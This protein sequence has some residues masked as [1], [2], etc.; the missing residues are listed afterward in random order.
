M[1]IRVSPH[2]VDPLYRLRVEFV[3]QHGRHGMPRGEQVLTGIADGTLSG[4]LLDDQQ[5]Y[6]LFHLADYNGARVVWLDELYLSPAARK[7]G[8]LQEFADWL[9][10][11]CRYTGLAAIMGTVFT[12]AEGEPFLKHLGAEPVC[13][14]L[15]VP[16]ATLAYKRTAVPA[17]VAV[18]VPE[19]SP[20]GVAPEAPPKDFKP[21]KKRNVPKYAIDTNGE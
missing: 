7:Q 14:I 18:P 9:K 6:A 13:M 5:G 11:Y 19:P 20:N 12:A 2:S 4:L 1:V 15:R 17:A 10:E 21:R 3:A 8:R 16:A